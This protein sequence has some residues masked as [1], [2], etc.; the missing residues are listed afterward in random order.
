MKKWLVITGPT[1]SGKTRL[2]VHIAHHLN[3]EVVSIDSRQVFRSMDLGTGK[4]LQEYI[5]GGRHVPVHLVD[6]RDPGE[7]YHIAAFQK[8]FDRVIDDIEKCGKIPVLCGGSGLYLEAV[9]EGHNLTQIPVNEKFRASCSKK[10]VDELRKMLSKGIPLPYSVDLKSRKRIIRA[11]EIQQYLASHPHPANMQ[12]T[13]DSEIFILDLPR[14][15]RRKR[16]SSRLRERFSEGMLEEVQMLRRQLSDEQ[17]IR[18]GLEYKWITLYLKGDLSY[19]EMY[20]KLETEIH[21]F[22]KRQMTWF[23]RLARKRSVHWLDATLPSEKLIQEIIS[24]Y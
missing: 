24:K 19:P 14:E 15:E 4:D 18:Y 6:I 8:D 12:G 9:L 20:T 23:R 11:L 3:G 10:P 5:I 17:L 2:A 13:N 7:D 1:A 21:R 16:I 22:S